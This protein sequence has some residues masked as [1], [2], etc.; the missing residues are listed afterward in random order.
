[1]ADRTLIEWADATINPFPGCSHARLPDG[2]VSPACGG[3]CY[4]ERVA[5]RMST[6]PV[7]N[8]YHG[9]AVFGQDGTPAWTGQV[10][11]APQDLEK[12]RKWT[13]PRRIFVESM[14]DIAHESL[15]PQRWL[16]F[17]DLLRDNVSRKQPHTYYLLTKRPAHLRLLLESMRRGNALGEPSAF[18]AAM[19]PAK[20]EA[21]YWKIMQ[22]VVCMAT[23]ENQAAADYRVPDLVRCPALHFGVS[24]EPLVG[25][26][27]LR[28]WLRRP[29]DLRVG[30]ICD[31]C[32]PGGVDEDGCCTSCGAD[33]REVPGLGW[34]ITGG[35]T[36]P[37]AT[38]S[39]PQWSRDLRDQ[40]RGAGVP[41]F[42]KQ[43]GEWAQVCYFPGGLQPG[44]LLMLP[45]GR[46]F[47]F[48]SKVDIP[49]DAPLAAEM[50]RVGKRAA[51]RL[52]DG[53]E[54]SE[55]PVV[56]EGALP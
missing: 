5:A 34:I 45:D 20:M 11:F 37:R 3:G 54:H 27:D 12:P 2:T 13:R 51:G 9:L 23:T 50:C 4:A 56:G 31:A 49:V 43:H 53:V 41:F 22:W 36:G 15:T 42:F 14:G 38:P 55:I 32:G 16:P 24:A 18:A 46:T 28:R 10:G 40:A 47:T 8:K 29:G 21:L 26:L 39:H 30:F 52:L 35:W 44:N 25:P 6:N 1:M 19:G 33:A 48:A 7:V 17:W